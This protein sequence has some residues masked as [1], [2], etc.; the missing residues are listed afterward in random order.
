M[1]L[2]PLVSVQ[3]WF[4]VFQYRLEQQHPE[5]IILLFNHETEKG[6]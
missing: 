6:E 5:L 2:V 4:K 3:G 1:H